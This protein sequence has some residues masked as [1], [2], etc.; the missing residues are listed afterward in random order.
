MTVAACKPRRARSP[1]STQPRSLS[2][3]GISPA[4]LGKQKCGAESAGLLLAVDSEHVAAALVRRSR[5]QK[6]QAPS[7]VYRSIW[8]RCYHANEAASESVIRLQQARLGDSA[9][10]G[11]SEVT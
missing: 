1:A 9:R 11:S 7:P 2:V 5:G 3:E 10:C 4:G 6:A 8:H